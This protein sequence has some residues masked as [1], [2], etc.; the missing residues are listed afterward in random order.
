MA[1]LILTNSEYKLKRLIQ[2]NERAGFKDY[3][4]VKGKNALLSAHKKRVKKIENLYVLNDGDYCSVVGT[5]IYKE[6]HGKDA[7]ALIYKDFNGNPEEI[8]RNAIGNY[9]I[10]VHKQGKVFAFVDKYQ[11]LKAYYYNNGT[12]WLLTNSLTDM[13]VAVDKLEIDEFEFIQETMLLGS[14][15]TNSMFKGVYRLFGHQYIE[16]I[17]EYNRFELRVL[18]YT[19]N[20]RTFED[21]TIEDAVDEYVDIIKEKFAVVAKVFGDNIR[22]QQTGGLD[23][24][25]IFS[26]FMS[27]G[28]KPKIMYGVGNSLL[29]N[30]KDEDYQI[31]L[32]Y[33]NK[34]D[35][36]FY[37]MNWRENYI[38]NEE[39]WPDLFER[40]GFNYRIYGGGRNF[41]NEYEGKIPDYPDFIELGMF[42]ENLRLREWAKDHDKNNFTIDEFIDFYLLGGAYG[43]ITNSQD[44]FVANLDQL[45]IHIYTILECFMGLYQIRGGGGR[46]ITIDDFDQVRWIHSRNSDSL[47]VN[48]LNEFVSSI[49]MLSIP[50]LHEFPFDVPAK[51]RANAKFQLKVINKLLPEA[52][53][54]PIFSHCR[55][56][57][58]DRKTFEIKPIK[59]KR[60][61]VR[62]ILCKFG[63]SEV[64]LKKIGSKVKFLKKDNR[65]KD[66]ESEKK[67][68]KQYLIKIIEDDEK[69]AGQYIKAKA[70]QG[71]LVYLMIYAQYLH[72]IKLL[73]LERGDLTGKE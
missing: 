64:M 55:V 31:C 53:D 65:H 25:T 30:T 17:P 32:K 72:G 49:A 15:G 6:K 4:I 67:R 68:L 21:K 43:D 45:K 2:R 12:D 69:S 50:E 56:N 58:F 73:L 33:K 22:I 44:T 16:I 39:N 20:R 37:E 10:V 34:F 8:R 14:I 1:R 3:R 52:L 40:Y 13:G 46:S 48:Y 24:R 27:V 71:S 47:F 61:K 7:L 28:C 62:D 18:P 19:R 36:D 35:L 57:H 11:I 29:T 41:F 51:W 9:L 66:L 70:Y 5:C 63:F 26:A 59:S 38:G 42:G 60:K 23:N 54:V